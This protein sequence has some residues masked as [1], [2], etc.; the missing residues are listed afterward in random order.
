MPIYCIMNFTFSLLIVQEIC[1]DMLAISVTFIIL[2]SKGQKL[3]SQEVLQQG[4]IKWTNLAVSNERLLCLL[5]IKY[6]M[7]NLSLRN[8]LFLQVFLSRPEYTDWNMCFQKCYDALY[9]IA[10]S[11]KLVHS[12]EKKACVN[13]KCNFLKFMLTA[14]LYCIPDWQLVNDINRGRQKGI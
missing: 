1:R 7:Q 2:C 3:K 8:I 11:E 14:S 12:K 10:L 6:M 13:H 5:I 4:D 9:M